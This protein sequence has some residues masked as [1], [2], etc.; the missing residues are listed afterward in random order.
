MYRATITLDR[1]AARATALNTTTSLTTKDKRI[2]AT[3]NDVH[4]VI[5][6]DF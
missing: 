6:V 4:E 5:I 1:R 2:E 3:V